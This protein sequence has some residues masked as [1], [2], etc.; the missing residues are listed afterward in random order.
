[1][2]TESPLDYTGHRTH[3]YQLTVRS[4]TW[5][6]HKRSSI[7]RLV[8]D[9]A[10]WSG[11]SILYRPLLLAPI[12]ALIPLLFELGMIV[13]GNTPDWSNAIFLSVVLA[14]FAPPVAIPIFVA[15]RGRSRCWRF[16]DASVQ[17]VARSTDS[18]VR[19]LLKVSQCYIAVAQGNDLDTGETVTVKL[20]ASDQIPPSAWLLL[21]APFGLH[22]AARSASTW[23]TYCASHLQLF[24]RRPEAAADRISTLEAEIGELRHQHSNERFQFRWSLRVLS[25]AC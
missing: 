3:V 2:D 10:E 25:Q 13:R 6:P 1:M 14:V 19:E 12:F 18:D 4:M 9:D 7:A 15:L 23:I 21:D 8:C 17:V 22:P 16:L 5:V 24:A 11:A 20:L